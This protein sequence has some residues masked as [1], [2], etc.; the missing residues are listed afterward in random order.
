[1]YTESELALMISDLRLELA[2]VSRAILVFEDLAFKEKANRK[3]PQRTGSGRLS[4]FCRP[5]RV[6]GND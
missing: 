2:R 4:S 1:M 6:A 5:A 3:R